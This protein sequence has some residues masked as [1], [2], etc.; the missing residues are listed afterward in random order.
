V[1]TRD[2]EQPLGNPGEER[3]VV[4]VFREADFRLENPAKSM[5]SGGDHIE[6][7]E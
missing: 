5:W 6:R 1:T 4:R 7:L 3:D 2:N